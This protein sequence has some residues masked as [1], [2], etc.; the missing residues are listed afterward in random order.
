MTVAFSDTRGPQSGL[1]DFIPPTRK[2]PHSIEAEMALLGAIIVNNQAYERV[3]EYLRPEHF[4]LAEHRRIFESCARLIERGQIADPV[5]LK[6][7]LD[8]TDALAGAG[9]IAYLARLADAAVT[10]FSLSVVY[11]V[12]PSFNCLTRCK[13]KRFI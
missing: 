9:G 12:A 11:A 2:L 8:Q 13:D 3:S 7:Y 10:E 6:A 1:A 4:A 5:T